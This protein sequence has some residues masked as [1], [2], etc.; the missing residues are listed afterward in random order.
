MDI[1]VSLRP[2]FYM[3]PRPICLKKGA[4]MRG[5]WEREREYLF[6]QRTWVPSTMLLPGDAQQSVIPVPGDQTPSSGFHKH[7]MPTVHM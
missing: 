1:W 5:K 2:V 6:L 3:S 7:C 4:E